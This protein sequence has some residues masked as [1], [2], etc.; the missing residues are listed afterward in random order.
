MLYPH[1]VTR[2]LDQAILSQLYHEGVL[3]Y[4]KKHRLTESKLHN[5]NV[6]A[7]QLC[8][9]QQKSHLHANTVKLIHQWIP[10]NDY[11]HKQQCLHHNLCSRCN[12][13][14]ET[15]NHI[16]Q[17]PAKEPV[18]SRELYLYNALSLMVSFDTKLEI[19]CALEKYLTSITDSKLADSPMETHTC[20]H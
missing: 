7:L 14:L 11:W 17:C 5:V 13:F 4:I 2:K 6:T 16:L 3:T 15:S 10:T 18:S 8:L 1:K 19:L 20:Q 12:T 9:S